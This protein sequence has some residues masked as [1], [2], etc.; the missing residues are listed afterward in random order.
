MLQFILTPQ[1]YA[2]C[3]KF[4]GSFQRKTTSASVVAELHYW[5]RATERTGQERLWNR[6]YDGFREMGMDEQ[7]VNLL[8]MDV[9][10]VARFGPVDVSLLEIAKREAGLSPLVLTSDNDLWRECK[11]AELPVQDLRELA[12]TEQ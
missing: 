8:K 4:I 5:I 2:H 6:Y 11:S 3:G 9:G 10:L 1:S 12:L 7:L